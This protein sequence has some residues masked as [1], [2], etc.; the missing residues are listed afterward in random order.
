MLI[1]DFQVYLTKYLKVVLILLLTVYFCLQK[2]QFLPYCWATLK[3]TN[4]L[5]GKKNKF[6]RKGKTFPRNTS[7][8]MTLLRNCHN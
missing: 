6:Q 2:M 4:S 5:R 1:K 8:E 3:A 7:V